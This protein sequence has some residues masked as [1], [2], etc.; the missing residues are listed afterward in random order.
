M[1]FATFGPSH[2]VAC[3][4]HDASVENGKLTLHPRI[5]LCHTAAGSI[6]PQPHPRWESF[7]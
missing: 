3:F 7:E 6:R 1:A 4:L 2:P 5:A